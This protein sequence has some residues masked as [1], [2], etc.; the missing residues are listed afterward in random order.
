MKKR[1]IIIIFIAIVVAIGSWII[2][3]QSNQS[4]QQKLIITIAGDVVK[5][6]PLSQDTN[7][8]FRV[9]SGDEWNDVVITNGVV[10]VVDANCST[11]VCVKTKEAKKAGDI[12]VCLPH[13]MIIEIK[14]SE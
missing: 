12:I 7:D 2:I 3:D 9:Q 8:S 14:P 4:Q 5:E 10:D 13:K 1:D 6:I 11:H